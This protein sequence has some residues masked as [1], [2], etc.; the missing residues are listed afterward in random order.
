MR[1]P[2]GIQTIRKLSNSLGGAS[3]I[4]SPVNVLIAA[5]VGVFAFWH[6]YA[7]DHPQW[8]RVFNKYMFLSNSRVQQSYFPLIGHMFMHADA[9]HLFSNMIA[10]KSFGDALLP[11]IGTRNF[12]G[13][14]FAAGLIGAA[15][16]LYYHRMAPK[17][18]MPASQ[19]VRWDNVAVGASAAIAGITVLSCAMYP[20]GSVLLF[21]L[22]VPNVVFVAAFVAWSVYGAYSGA[23]HSW[24]HAAHLGGALTGMGYFAGRR[25]LRLA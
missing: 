23:E 21:I 18:A 10:L 6:L 11:S 17:L 8:R 15:T 12:V 14:Y 20:K 13:L 4:V 24:A 25:I 19:Y 2:A 5:N 7:W 3:S 1:S 9:F 16:Q 22:P